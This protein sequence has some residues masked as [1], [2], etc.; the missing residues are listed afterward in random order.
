MIGSLKVALRYTLSTA[1]L[2]GI[3][4]PLLI[5]A[6]AQLGLK[7][8][9][10]GSLITSDSGTVIGSGLIGQNFAGGNYF[11][12]RPSAAGNGYDASNSSGSNLAQSSHKLVAR[13]EGD[14]A[15]DRPNA[16]SRPVP[17][18]MVT[19]SGSGLDPDITP[20][21]AIY[22]SQRIAATRNLS[23]AAVARLVQRHTTPRQ[24]GFLGEPRVN[25]LEINLAL[26]QLASGST[27]K[28]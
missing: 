1:V 5:T 16:I 4:Y 14:V 2:L 9:A 20:A 13:I 25:V 6:L 12:G 27:P 26:D 17:I 22:Q 7:R 18:D 3:I 10:N 11:H 24:F 21:A 28:H 19:A 15:T 23:A 8:Q